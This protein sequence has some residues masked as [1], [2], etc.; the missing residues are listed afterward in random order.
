M[1]QSEQQPTWLSLRRHL[2]FWAD[3]S[4]CYKSDHKSQVAPFDNTLSIQHNQCI[5]M[6]SQPKYMHRSYKKKK[7]RLGKS[8][9]TKRDHSMADFSIFHEDYT[10]TLLETCAKSINSSV[11]FNTGKRAAPVGEII[12]LSLSTEMPRSGKTE[13]GQFSD[14]LSFKWTITVNKAW[15]NPAPHQ[16]VLNS[17]LCNLL[18]K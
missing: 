4:R 15:R 5:A 14:V 8:C 18:A 11:F 16:L 10:M 3:Y 13:F 2:I 6:K 12:K 7:K 17:D 9:Q 1:N